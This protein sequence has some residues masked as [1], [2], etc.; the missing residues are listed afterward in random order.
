MGKPHGE[1]VYLEGW[2]NSSQA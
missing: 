2:E 1:T